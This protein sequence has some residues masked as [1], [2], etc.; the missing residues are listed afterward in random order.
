MPPRHAAKA[1]T[2]SEKYL[3]EASPPRRKSIQ[4]RQRVIRRAAPSVARAFLLSRRWRLASVNLSVTV[5]LNA[6]C[7]TSVAMIAPYVCANKYLQLKYNVPHYDRQ[8][9]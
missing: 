3:V 5:V 8:V 4:N 2:M 7:G 6:P 9:R 1:Y